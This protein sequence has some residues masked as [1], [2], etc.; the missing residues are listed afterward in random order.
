M[1]GEHQ[2]L[3]HPGGPVSGMGRPLRLA[4][5]GGSRRWGPDRLLRP[6]GPLRHPQRWHRGPLLSGQRRRD[7]AGQRLPRRPVPDPLQ[8]PRPSH[9]RRLPP[10]QSHRRPV[11][12]MRLCQ[13]VLRKHSLIGHEASPF[14]CSILIQGSRDTRP[15]V[16]ADTAGAVSLQS[17]FQTQVV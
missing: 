11:P 15:R 9:R 1:D 10:T 13:K 4:G 8:P 14:V 3:P 2:R 16:S 7:R 12:K 6:A 17:F 5:P